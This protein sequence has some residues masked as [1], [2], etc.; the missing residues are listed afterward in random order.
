MTDTTQNIKH[1]ARDAKGRVLPKVTDTP[2]KPVVDALNAALIAI[3]TRHPEIPNAVLV[4]GTS[5]SKKNGHFSPKSWESKGA[6]HEIMLSGESLKRGADATLGTLIHECAH[7]L[8]EKRE[9]KD[10]S[11]QGRF[12]NTKF[13]VLAEELGIEVE[14]DPVI[15]WSITTLPKATAAL[16]KP[17]IAGLKKALTAYRIPDVAKATKPKT[18]VKIECGCRSV[19]VPISFIEKGDITCDECGETFLREDQAPANGMGLND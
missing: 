4:V 12:H 8:A 14:K 1:Q 5:S 15:G 9:I 13:K 11:R 2:I 6:E 18:T 19:T 10:T 17:E 7:A 3:R 16:Y